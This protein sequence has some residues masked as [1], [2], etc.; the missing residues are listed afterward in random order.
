MHRL[1]AVQQMHVTTFAD[2]ESLNMNMM[3]MLYS[4]LCVLFY[5]FIYLLFCCDPPAHIYM[6]MWRLGR[7]TSMLSTVLEMPVVLHIGIPRI[8]M[9]IHG[10]GTFVLDRVVWGCQHRHP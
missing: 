4:C 3:E 6:R 8:S 5:L 2:H 10:Y 1:H 9:R 7:P